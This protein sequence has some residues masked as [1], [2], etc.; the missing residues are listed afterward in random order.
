MGIAKS[1]R[2][3][4]RKHYLYPFLTWA[5]TIAALLVVYKLPFIVV[6]GLHRNNLTVPRMIRG[7]LM[8]QARPGNQPLLASTVGLD[9]LQKAN[10]VG[11]LSEA[12]STGSSAT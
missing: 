10:T 4:N 8:G 9:T 2:S 3:Q 1:R 11:A 12:T 6:D 5:A 7:V